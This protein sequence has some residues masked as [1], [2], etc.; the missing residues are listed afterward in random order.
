MKTRQGLTITIILLTLIL[1]GCSNLT[2]V[3]GPSA[4]HAYE[5]AWLNASDGTLIAANYYPST[6]KKG[7]ILIP[8][9][10]RYKEDYDEVATKLME[11]YKILAYDLRGQG[12]SQGS[13]DPDDPQRYKDMTLDLIAAVKTLQ[14]LGVNESNISY[15]G[16]SIGASTIVN[17]LKNHPS[18]KVVLISPGLR[19]HGIDIS[20]ISLQQPLLIQVGHYDAYAS[21]STDDLIL[22]WPHARVLNYDSSAHGTDLITYDLSAHEDFLFYLS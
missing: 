7:L 6:S 10:G 1:T 4:K 16:A 20:T 5:E 13:A 3:R 14:E 12:E 9:L 19:Y 21:L 22:L 2:V 18:D 17:Y 8:G 11:N 15:V